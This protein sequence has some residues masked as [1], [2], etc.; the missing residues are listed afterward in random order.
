MKKFGAHRIICDKDIIPVGICEITGGRV[1]CIR[2]LQ[3]EE[4]MVEW[5]DGEIICHKDTQNVLHAYYK[6][7]LLKD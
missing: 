5:L 7:Q 2:K 3:G 6:N 4:A 1:V